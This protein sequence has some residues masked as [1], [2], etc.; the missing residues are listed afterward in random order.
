[1]YITWSCYTAFSRR[2]AVTLTSLKIDTAVCFIPLYTCSPV[3]WKAR[4]ALMVSKGYVR[5]TAVTPAQ[6]PANSLARWELLPNKEARACKQIFKINK[7]TQPHNSLQ[8]NT[9]PYNILRDGATI[10]EFFGNVYKKRR[11]TKMLITRQNFLNRT[12]N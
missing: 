1:M 12:S 10:K 2:G 11:K 4:R 9:I 7:D 8:V 3:T 5:E 6:E